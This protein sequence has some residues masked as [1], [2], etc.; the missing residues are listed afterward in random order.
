MGVAYGIYGLTPFGC[1]A[2]LNGLEN[3]ANLRFA[4]EGS[5]YCSP[6][7]MWRRS[8]ADGVW[9]CSGGDFML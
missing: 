3:S 8:G 1:A 2:A 9:A 6:A 7:A 5:F 4:A